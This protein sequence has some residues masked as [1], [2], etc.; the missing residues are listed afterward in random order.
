[1]SVEARRA[2]MDLDLLELGRVTDSWWTLDVG[3]RT[4]QRLLTV[5]PSF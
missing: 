4:P 5:K 3:T 1:M 2:S